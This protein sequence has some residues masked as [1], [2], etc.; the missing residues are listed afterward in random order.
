MKWLRKMIAFLFQTFVTDCPK[1]H[2]FFFGF[3][4]YGKQVK[5]NEVTYRILCHRCFKQLGSL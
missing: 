3:Q 5:M 4:N 2:S 1:C